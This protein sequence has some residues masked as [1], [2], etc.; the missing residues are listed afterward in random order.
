MV[1]SLLPLDFALSD[2][3]EVDAF[4]IKHLA[5]LPECRLG[6]LDAFNLDSLFETVDS[7]LGDGF[8]RLVVPITVDLE[9]TARYRE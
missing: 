5:V 4:D 3:R 1:E 8:G 7:D 2:Q 9:G 6:L